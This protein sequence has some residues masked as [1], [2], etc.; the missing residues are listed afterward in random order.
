MELFSCIK[1]FPKHCKT[2]LQN[3]YRN[4][5]MSVSSVFSVTIM[6]LLIGLI[7]LVSINIYDMTYDI[8]EKLT[9]YVQMDRTLSDE[10]ASLIKPTIEAIE[11]VKSATFFTKEE[12]LNKII[13]KQSESGKE[14]FESYRD[15][16]PLGAAY[17]VEVYNTDDLSV[18][19]QQIAEIE[20]VKTVEDG[21]ND[22]LTLIDGLD[23]LR[24]GGT[25][26]TAVL[27]IMALLMISNTIKMTITARQ[28][29]ISIMRMVGASNWYIR[30]PFMLEGVFIGILGSILPLL[31]L[32]VGYIYVY[33]GAADFFAGMIALRAPIPF[34]IQSGF[35]LTILGCSVG[36]IGSFVSIRRFLKF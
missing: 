15:N 27:C 33:N 30:L 2:A 11:G 25:V 12:E 26:F 29:E 21:G 20:N 18:I 1:N 4:G 8:E 35:V 19:A 5:V 16:N 28:T 6:L 32:S 7:G 14:L 23:T 9:I 36:L 31:A 17:V 24:T 13:E 22:A 34:L 10:K 3:I